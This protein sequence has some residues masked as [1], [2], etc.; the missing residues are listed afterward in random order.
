MPP[1]GSNGACHPKNAR[2]TLQKG[3]GTRNGDRKL[4]FVAARKLLNFVSAAKLAFMTREKR[5]LWVA[6]SRKLE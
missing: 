4:D 2:P 3:W 5:I 1:N 6:F